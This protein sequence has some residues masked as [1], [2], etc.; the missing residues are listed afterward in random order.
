MYCL[1][2]L[3]QNLISIGQMTLVYASIKENIYLRK[4]G[5]SLQTQIEFNIPEVNHP[6][7]NKLFGQTKSK[8]L[9]KRFYILTV[10]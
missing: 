4:Y 3:E 5:R 7:I 8:N 10:A 6:H 1:L 2:L 9:L